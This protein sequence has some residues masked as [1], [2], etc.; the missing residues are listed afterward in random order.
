[1]E[2]DNQQIS[3]ADLER[4]TNLAMGFEPPTQSTEQNAEPVEQQ[5]IEIEQAPVV[6]SGQ[7]DVSTSI[8]QFLDETPYGGDDIIER[9]K[10]TV[11][12]YKNIQSEFT[13]VK[14]KLAP[15]EQLLNDLETD[16]QL[17]EYINQ[18]VNLYRNPQLA[19]AYLNNQNP[20]LRPDPRNYDMSTVEGYDQYN[21]E[22]E[23]FLQRQ[24][25]SRINARFGQIEQQQEVEKQKYAFKQVFPEVNPDEAIEQVKKKGKNW[26]LADA[27]KAL[28]YDNLKTKLTESIRKELTQQLEKAGTTASPQN[29]GGATTKLSVTD[30]IN[31]INKYGGES[32]KK[33]FGDKA[34]QQ[35]MQKASEDF[36]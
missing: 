11:D 20:D 15:H 29:N 21:R 30:I 7:A 25:D 31:H 2:T 8:K 4:E 34:F 10:K 17:Q 6:P 18:A 35:A 33:K 32:A 19:Q 1:M 13:K 12:G 5:E 9:V 24:L 26:T 28:D 27:Y 22:V 3:E 14:Q 16:K 36:L 23:A